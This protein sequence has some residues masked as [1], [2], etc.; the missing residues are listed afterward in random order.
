[1]IKKIVPCG[2]HFQ[3]KLTNL[4]DAIELKSARP[5]FMVLIYPVISMKSSIA[6]NGSQIGTGGQHV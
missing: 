6:H 1:M 3:E 5:D 2:T 4:N